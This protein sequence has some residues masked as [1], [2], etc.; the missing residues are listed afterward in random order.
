LTFLAEGGKILSM[1]AANQTE[2]R[3]MILTNG[4]RAV[5]ITQQGA[6]VWANLYVNA[7]HGVEHATIMPSRWEGKTMKGAQKWATE[8]L[9]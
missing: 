5:V 1:R 7:R 9:A 4:S 3:T 2:E 8:R 6:T